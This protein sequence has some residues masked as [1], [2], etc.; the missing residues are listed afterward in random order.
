LAGAQLCEESKNNPRRIRQI[1]PYFFD[2]D[3]KDWWE[4]SLR[5]YLSKS[6][7]QIFD[8]FMRFFFEAEESK[9][10]DAHQQTLLQNLVQ[11]A[12]QKKIDSLTKALQDTRLNQNQIKYVLD[13]LKTTGSDAALSVIEEADKKGWNE[14]TR[15]RAEDIVAEATVVPTKPAVVEEAAPSSFRNPFE[16]NVEYILIPGGSFYYKVS[17]KEVTVPD[18]YFCKYPVT[19]K[20]YRRFISYLAGEAEELAPM[21]PLD[22]FA[23]KLRTFAGS[24]QGFLEKSGKQPEEW[25]KAF[26]SPA[27]DDRRFNGPDQPV[28]GITWYAARAY[29]FWLSCLTA[30]RQ[31]DFKNRDVD[32]VASIYRLPTE[33]EWEWAAAGREPDGSLREYPWPKTKGQPTPELANYGQNVDATTPVGRYPEGAT[34]EGLMDM[35]GNVWE[36]M[37]NWYDEDEDVRALRGGSWV[38]DEGVLRCSAR[39]NYD[40]GIRLLNFGFRVLRCQV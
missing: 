2:D 20:R 21:L 16:D 17:K 36:W 9:E 3:L 26:R 34:P 18:M 27:D 4:E 29:C 32:A 23:P 14:T 39:L 11:E 7:E 15:R 31:G 24:I 1:I 19:N 6:T 25:L 30:A 28:V 5:F 38:D 37:E 40:P 8:L 13:C 12:P 35:A 10:L 33:W 22:L